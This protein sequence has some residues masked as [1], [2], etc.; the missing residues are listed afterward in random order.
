MFGSSGGAVTGLALVARHPG[1]VRT[2]V[3]HEPPLLGL[4]ADAAQQRANTEDIIATFHAHGPDA[5]WLAF[6]TNAGFDT[7]APG[8]APARPEPSEQEHQQQLDHGMRFFDH[9]LRATTGFEPDLAALRRGATRVV[10]GVGVDSGPL[11]TH[12]T[13]VALAEA[14]GAPPVAFPGDHGGFIGKPGEFA[15]TLRKV[16]IGSS[17]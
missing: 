12:R 1:R 13:S 15:A 6:M 5:A 14:L 11:L 8:G 10:V 3:A 17:R 7:T 2:L 16:L 4:L 9:E